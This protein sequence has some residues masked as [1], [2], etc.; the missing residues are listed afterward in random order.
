MKFGHLEQKLELRRC[1]K[2]SS[3]IMPICWWH[4]SKLSGCVMNVSPCGFKV[5]EFALKF[6]KNLITNEQ[7]AVLVLQK[8]NTV[9]KWEAH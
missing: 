8:E 3:K 1:A 4:G 5:N 7:Y 9:E 2:S 6:S